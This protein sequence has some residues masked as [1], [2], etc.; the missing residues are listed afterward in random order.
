MR[1]AGVL[2][3]TCLLAATIGCKSKNDA[4]AASPDPAAAKAQEELLKRR[5]ALISTR[6]KLIQDKQS[7]EQEIQAGSGSGV[8]ITPLQR[9]LADI[10][11]KLDNNGNDTQRLL[12]EEQ[13]Q[14]ATPPP[15]ADGGNAEV[16][17]ELETLHQLEADARS[18]AAAADKALR[19]ALAAAD[20]WK[21]SCTVGGTTIIQQAAPTP[22]AKG[23]FTKGDV[24]GVLARARAAMNRKGLR[25][26][27]LGAAASLEGEANKAMSDGEWAHAMG[28]AN[29][30]AAAVD[31]QKIDKPFILGKFERLKAYV[32][33]HK[34]AG[35]QARGAL[36]DITQK[37]GDQNYAG[38]NQR[39]NELWG[40][41]AH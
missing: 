33:A 30:L 22:P 23:T 4:D 34:E 39:I 24:Q 37:F 13:T 3:M 2:V 12:Q 9:Q 36:Q 18:R 27:D 7:I 8:D 32:A 21:D 16:A 1:I 14:R 15:T 40:Q 29:Q 35:D 20:K 10:Q 6:Q 38:A 26:D 28:A 41:L 17:R 25:S 19:D 5:D 11:A 31:Q